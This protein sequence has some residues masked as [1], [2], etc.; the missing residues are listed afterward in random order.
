MGLN[1]YAATSR[2]RPKSAGH[3]NSRSRI[4]VANQLKSSGHREDPLGGYILGP[5]DATTERGAAD[6]DFGSAYP[7]APSSPAQSHLGAGRHGRPTRPSHPD[8]GADHA[9]IEYAADGTINTRLQYNNLKSKLSN[10]AGA[11]PAPKTH[12]PKSAGLL[13]ASGRR[14]AARGLNR[15]G[16]DTA[17]A[18]NGIQ[19]AQ[20]ESLWTATANKNAA[21]EFSAQ[22][23]SRIEEELNNVDMREDADDI[24]QQHNIYNVTHHTLDSDSDDDLEAAMAK[25]MKKQENKS[26]RFGERVRNK[27]VA[28][29]TFRGNANDV[30]FSGTMTDLFESSTAYTTSRF[31]FEE[32][33]RDRQLGPFEGADAAVKIVGSGISSQTAPGVK[34]PVAA[35]THL[36]FRSV[37]ELEKERS[38]RQFEKH[39][40][41]TPAFLEAAQLEEDRA[42]RVATDRVPL[43]TYQTYTYDAAHRH[44]AAEEN[45]TYSG[46]G[47]SAPYYE[48]NQHM[49]ESVVSSKDNRAGGAFVDDT[50][51]PSD[52][53]A[54]RKKRPPPPPSKKQ[55]HA[56]DD[57]VDQGATNSNIYFPQGSF[58]SG[59]PD[60]V[61]HDPLQTTVQNFRAVYSGLTWD[62]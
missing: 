62:F 17:S 43:D 18:A 3:A 23:M 5:D 42:R 21:V 16:A 35:H 61:S 25:W 28:S 29:S 2:K 4:H 58:P 38:K 54:S 56:F 50:S 9:S 34:I 48:E 11:G 26:M 49:G 47:Y 36:Q 15:S 55:T 40:G 1:A 12:R 59:P 6:S 19:N 10:S 33:V 24:P 44:A 14:Q 22:D 20:S 27:S 51:V 53:I 52:R 7:V 41:Y 32:R 39:N 13:G 30:G 60:P 45:A 8:R 31:E 57:S 46:F 37:N